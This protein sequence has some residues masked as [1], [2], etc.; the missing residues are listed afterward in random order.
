MQHVSGADSA[1]PTFI[2]HSSKFIHH[3]A[4]NISRNESS[5][6]YRIS[7]FYRPLASDDQTRKRPD[8][9]FHTQPIGIV[10]DV[11]LIKSDDNL[12]GEEKAKTEKHTAAVQKHNCIFIPFIM[13]TRGTLGCKAETFIRTLAKSVQPHYQKVFSRTINH[14]AQVAAAKGRADALIAAVDRLRW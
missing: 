14:S 5:S 7:G 8:L 12:E 10:T 9:F 13:H 1:T 6:E 3:R 4:P 2:H 11:S